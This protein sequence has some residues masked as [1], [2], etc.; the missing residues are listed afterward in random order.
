MINNN[1]FKTKYF[2]LLKEKMNL[3]RYL[4]DKIKTCNDRID[5]Y[6]RETD[7]AAL[8]VYEEILSKI[9]KGNYE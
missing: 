7:M 8:Y 4:E 3:I 9:K 2:S 1:I 5:K 6:D